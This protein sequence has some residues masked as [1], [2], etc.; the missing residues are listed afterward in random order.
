MLDRIGRFYN[1]VVMQSAVPANYW[2]NVGLT[3][4]YPYFRN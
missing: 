3:L 2:Q 1:A 4:L